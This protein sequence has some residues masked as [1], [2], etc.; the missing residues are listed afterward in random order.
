MSDLDNILVSIV[1]PVYKVEKY[2]YRCVESVQK[3]THKY[4]QIILVDDGSPDYCPR[5]CDELAQKDSRIIVIHKRN[6]GLASAR[7]AG[8]EIASGKYLFFLDSDDWIDSNTIGELIMYAEKSNVDFVRFRPMYAGWPHHEDGSLCDFHTEDCLNE[9]VYTKDEIK[10]ILFPKLIVTP[11]LSLGPIVAVWRSLYNLEFLKHYKIKFDDE[12]KYSEDTIFSAK[13]VMN[14]TSFQYID[15][16][17]YYH[18][19]YNPNSITK[20]F[21]SD[22][23]VCYKKLI[24]SFECEFSNNQE[25]DFSNQLWLQKI[26]YVLSAISQR[27][28]IGEYE[29]RISYCREICKDPITIEALKHKNLVEGSIKL[30]IILLLIKMEAVRI[31]AR[32]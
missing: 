4:L 10:K 8:L 15:G 5:I 16:A 21:K 17:R 6:G 11:E 26:Y 27:K 1:M 29:K 32:I 18:Y 30:K 19:F 22:R 12:T 14:A 24:K 20:S 28:L 23:W 3:Q 13:V 9:K 2:L 31:L 7:N 25:Y